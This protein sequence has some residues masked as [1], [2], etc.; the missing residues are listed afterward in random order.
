MSQN[1]LHFEEQC[2]K[3]LKVSTAYLLSGNFPPGVG[4]FNLGI[5]VMMDFVVRTCW[6][7]GAILC[8]QSV[9]QCPWALPTPDASNTLPNY[10]NQ[11]V[12]E[13][14]PRVWNPFLL[15]H[16]WES[17]SHTKCSRMFPIV[18]F[19]TIKNWKQLVFVNK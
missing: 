10:D 14:W 6:G 7:W 3:R 11:K 12:S 13:H 2:G 17:L 5:I 9:Q 16:Y 15:P 8:V 1:L 18:I 19:V 4:F